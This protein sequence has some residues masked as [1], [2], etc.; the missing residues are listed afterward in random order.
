[1]LSY[2]SGFDIHQLFTNLDAEKKGYLVTEDFEKY[3]E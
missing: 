2:H 3:F 1:M